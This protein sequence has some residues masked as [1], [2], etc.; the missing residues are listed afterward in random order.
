M[1]LLPGFA[2]YALAAGRAVLLGLAAAGPAA[3][4][5]RGAWSRWSLGLGTTARP[6][7]N[8][9]TCCCCNLPGFDGLRT[10]GRLMLWTTLLLALLAAGAVAALAERAAGWP[11]A[12][13]VRPAAVL[14]RAG[15]ARAVLL[16]FVEGWARRRTPRC[17]RRRPHCPLWTRPYLVLPTDQVGD[18]HVM[19]WS[20]DRFADVVNGGSGFVPTELDRTGA[21]WPDVPDEASVDYLRRLGVRTV[22]VVRSLAGDAAGQPVTPDEPR[23]STGLGHRPRDGSTGDA[24]VFTPL[25]LT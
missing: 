10:P 9:A 1:A 24:V 22:V 11:R 17:R 6:T 5:G 13:A 3:A 16:V 2:L 12:A 8:S 20:T 7:G 14:G 23:R 21:P 15:A 25:A 19:L 18:M 4:A